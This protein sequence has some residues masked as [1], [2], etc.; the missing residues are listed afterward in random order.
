MFL[1]RSLASLKLELVGKDGVVNNNVDN[2]IVNVNGNNNFGIN[3]D[4][5]NKIDND[6]RTDINN[7]ITFL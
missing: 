3:N 6:T 1:Y 4:A 7:S 2:T 5:G